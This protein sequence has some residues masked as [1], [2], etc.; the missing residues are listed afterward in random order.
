MVKEAAIIKAPMKIGIVCC[1]DGIR[2]G[3]EDEIEELHRTLADMGIESVFSPFLYARDGVASGTAEER[4][5]AVMDF[6]K[7]DTIDA[8][9]R[10]CVISG[11][12]SLCPGYTDARRCSGWKYPGFSENGRNRIYAGHGTDAKG[13]VIGAEL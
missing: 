9:W 3:Y 8:I 13:I 10:R 6:Y 5:K 2:Q 11:C 1:S 4:A 7:D 12:L